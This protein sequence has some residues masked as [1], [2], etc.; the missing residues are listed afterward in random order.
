[1]VKAGKYGYNIYSKSI[2]RCGRWLP[3]FNLLIIYITMWSF[4]EKL[5]EKIE[6]TNAATELKNWKVMS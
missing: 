3:Y 1:M 2:H 4:E 5:I 6:D